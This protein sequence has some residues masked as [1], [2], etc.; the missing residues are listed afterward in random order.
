MSNFSSSAFLP[1]C[2]TLTQWKETTLFWC[3]DGSVTSLLTDQLNRLHMSSVAQ[4]TRKRTWFMN[5]DATY[6]KPLDATN[7]DLYSTVW[8]IVCRP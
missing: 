6:L 8:D 1:N 3:E 2:K 5:H 7:L 4:I